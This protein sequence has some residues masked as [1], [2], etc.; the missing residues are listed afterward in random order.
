[1][2]YIS[3]MP[4]PYDETSLVSVYLLVKSSLYISR[5]LPSKS[6]LE[7]V[8]SS[9]EK[10]HTSEKKPSCA[11]A[12]GGVDILP[13]A[14]RMP[15]PAITTTVIETAAIIAFFAVLYITPSFFTLYNATRD[16]SIP[17]FI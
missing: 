10:T 2:K 8:T 1:M 15:I 11:F 5:L 9:A 3:A 13:S 12:H 17:A 4:V 6:T 16:I 14:I 7:T